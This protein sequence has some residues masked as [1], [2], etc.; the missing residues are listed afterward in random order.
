[1]TKLVF[2]YSH[3]DEEL[4]N[5]LEIHLAPLTRQGLIDS[6]HDRRIDAGNEFE[7]DIDTNFLN[8]DIIL[9]LISPDF[10]ASDYCYH[11]EME[12]SINRHNNG[13]AKVIPVILRQCHWQELPFG[14]LMATPKDGKPVTKFTSLDDGFFEVVDAIKSVLAKTNKNNHSIKKQNTNFP[15]T[16]IT[17]E[18][19]LPSSKDRSSNL[20][21]KRTFS[22][23]EKDDALHKCFNYLS[24]FFENSLGELKTRN[25]LIETRFKQIDA[26]SFEATIYMNGTKKCH[27]GIWISNGHSYFRENG[28]LYSTQ[29]VTKNSINNSVSLKDDGYSLGFS[30]L[31]SF[32]YNGQNDRD[33]LLN[34]EGVSENF[35]DEFISPLQH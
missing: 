21:I 14:K 27:C 35:W 29:G 23:K 13:E 5:Q 8:A 31:N 7:R 24:N 1:M 30:L 10:I 9:L 25:S 20:R 11:I 22:D 17:T 3:K 2:S 6:W 18:N 28:I 12:S 15:N 33:K 16:I 34:D 32:H 4:R 26:N 19:P